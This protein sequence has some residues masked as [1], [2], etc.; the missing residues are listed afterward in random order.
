MNYK[1]HTLPNGI[2]LVHKAGKGEV[3]HCG[4]M[5]NAGSRDE[6]L[7]ELG[8]AHL[9]EHTIFKGTKKRKAYHI[10][11]RLENIGGEL[12]AYTSKE[13][14]CIYASIL[15]VYFERA[16]ELFADIIQNSV[17]PI[18][19]IEKEKE[20][21]IDELN[22][23][24]DNPLEQIH[25]EIEDLVF[26]GHP[27]GR[28]ILGTE[29]SLKTLNR[30]KII[31]FKNRNYTTDEMVICTLGN[32]KFETIVKITE[33]LFG[34]F[35]STKRL[36]SRKEF[37]K[38]IPKNI[39]KELKLHQAHCIIA[40]EAYG[41]NHPL[42]AELILLNNIL[43]GPGLNS[44]LNMG[45]REKYGFCYNIESNYNQFAE[46]GI[47]TVYMGTEFSSI[48]KT[49]QLV[50]KELQKLRNQKLGTMQLHFAKK[51]IIGQLAIAQESNI[52]ELLSF[53]KSIL[54][55]N[56][57]D[58]ISKIHKKFESITADKIQ[59][60]ANEIFTENKLSSILYTSSE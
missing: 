46:T 49:Q 51:Q 15:P 47:F 8:I 56:K 59:E 3:F 54:S 17:F 5:I 37:K 53:G 19:E 27:L 44:R 12:N 33:R 42:K 60:V 26:E 6:S 40:N 20:V 21:I 41:R 55:F 25:D 36:H 2:R 38:Y 4:L 58:S 48:D 43:G 31:A 28:N 7:S 50:L 30:N 1:L 9:I 34:Q 13:E 57:V 10:L 18:H 11:S 14:T 45:I 52:N 29:E 16:I 24:L 35:P 22:S 32:L 39:S 23:Y